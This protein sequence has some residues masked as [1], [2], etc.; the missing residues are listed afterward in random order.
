MFSVIFIIDKKEIPSFKKF[1]TLE[2]TNEFIK[3]SI[4]IL[5]KFFIIDNILIRSKHMNFSYCIT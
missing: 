2:K 3:T 1:E 4:T 5:Q